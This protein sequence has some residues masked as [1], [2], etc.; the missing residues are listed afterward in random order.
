MIT[1]TCL[2]LALGCSGAASASTTLLPADVSCDLATN[3]AIANFTLTPEHLYEYSWQTFIAINQQKQFSKLSLPAWA[4]WINT[5]TLAEVNY[6]NGYLKEFNTPVSVEGKDTRKNITT[7]DSWQCDSGCLDLDMSLKLDGDEIKM[8]G[9]RDKNNNPVFFEKRVNDKWMEALWDT[10]ENLNEIDNNPSLKDLAGFAFRWGSCG[11]G[12]TSAKQPQIALKLGWRILTNKDDKLRYITMENIKLHGFAVKQTLGLVAMHV[13]VGTSSN[14]LVG[15]KPTWTW[16]TFEQV[17]TLESETPKT[18][19]YSFI[20]QD[21]Y[22]CSNIYTANRPT[23][24]IR[25]EPIPTLAATYNDQYRSKLKK[26]N[27]VLQHYQL[28]GSQYP[29]IDNAGSYQRFDKNV[30]SVVF[31]PFLAQVNSKC[32]IPKSQWTVSESIRNKGSDCASCH[33]NLNYYYNENKIKWTERFKDF[34][35]INSGIPGIPMKEIT[36]N[37]KE[38]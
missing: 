24:L 10:K 33:N 36:L 29:H 12:N 13:G 1:R 11:Q 23:P 34:T 32:E 6:T 14:L 15:D 19:Q 18:I 37:P 7:A 28:I 16:L 17:D 8:L 3:N 21:E 31:E 25:D 22:S 2:L 26:Q 27:S 5:A 20:A 30:R 35:L 38:K 9:L 4:D